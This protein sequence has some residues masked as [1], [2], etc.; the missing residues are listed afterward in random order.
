MVKNIK[1]LT[2]SFFYKRS[3]WP[4]WK[5]IDGVIADGWIQSHYENPDS[6]KNQPTML[7]VRWVQI[8]DGT[9][10][11]LPHSAFIFK[12]GRDRQVAIIS[13]MEKEAGQKIQ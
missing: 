10:Y 5:K 13:N 11:E 1:D 2:Y 7:D 6:K 9:R 4:F 8:Y 12:W 3:W